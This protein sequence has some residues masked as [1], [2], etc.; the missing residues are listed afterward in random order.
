MGRLESMLNN[1]NNKKKPK[2]EQI[3]NSF[4]S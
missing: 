2:I 4:P 3:P 1:N